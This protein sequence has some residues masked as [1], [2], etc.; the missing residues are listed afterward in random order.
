MRGGSC[1]RVTGR[2]PLAALAALLLS[3]AL[4]A[5]GCL[6]PASSEPPIPGYDFSGITAAP[7]TRLLDPGQYK[8]SRPADCYPLAFVGLDGMLRRASPWS[9]GCTDLAPAQAHGSPTWRDVWEG[10]TAEPYIMFVSAAG[11][12]STLGVG[13]GEVTELPTP[14]DPEEEVTWLPDYF[15]AVHRNEQGQGLLKLVSLVDGGTE[16][17]MAFFGAWAYRPS[18]RFAALG[19]LVTSRNGGADRADMGLF[20]AAEGSTTVLVKAKSGEYLMPVGWVDENVL[21]YREAKTL[22]TVRFVDVTSGLAPGVAPPLPLA[23]DFGRVAGIIPANLREGWTG[24]FAVSPDGNKVAVETVVDGAPAVCVGDL[25]AAEWYLIG[26]GA[27]AAWGTAA[28]PCLG[29]CGEGESE[30]ALADA[31]RAFSDGDIVVAQAF[32]AQVNPVH[33]SYAEA[34]ELLARCRLADFS[35]VI[36]RD[37]TVVRDVLTGTFT[38]SQADA[39]IIHLSVESIDEVVGCA[40]CDLSYSSPGGETFAYEGQLT[41][42]PGEPFPAQFAGQ[43]RL[44]VAGRVLW[45]PPSEPVV[46]FPAGGSLIGWAVSLDCRLLAGTYVLQRD[47]ETVIETAVTDLL[48][49]ESTVVDGPYRP[50]S[51]MPPDWRGPFAGLWWT[52]AKTLRYEQFEGAGV[53]IRYWTTDG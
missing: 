26:S 25:E 46:I 42:G 13:T 19:V 8:A 28:V 35:S 4:A 1:S 51:S 37:W 38:L 30:Q 39:G 32:L 52:D 21:A 2:N 31:K 45:E 11:R 29:G 16:F 34:Q 6:L 53:E 12:I 50:G 7:S 5:A 23:L 44:V 40:Y 41:V 3:L 33:P 18:G 20:D 49:L 43:G 48:S 24:R 9:E 17:E 15:I 22:T 10:D 36:S 27:G 47:D 14:I